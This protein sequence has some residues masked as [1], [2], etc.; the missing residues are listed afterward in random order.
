[1][2]KRKVVILAIY[3]SQKVSNKDTRICDLLMQQF[4]AINKIKP[5][6]IS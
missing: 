4:T 6:E 2:D 5:P 3:N 1:M